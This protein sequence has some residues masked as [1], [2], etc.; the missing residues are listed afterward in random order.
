[1]D[2]FH[3]LL[4]QNFSFP[5]LQLSEFASTW[6]RQLSASSTRQ[7]R[8]PVYWKLASVPRMAQDYLKLVNNSIH[9]EVIEFRV[10]IG[11][12][13]LMS[14]LKIRDLQKKKKKKKTRLIDPISRTRFQTKYFA[15]YYQINHKLDT[16]YTIPIFS[17]K[18]KQSVHKH[19]ATVT[20][21]G[22]PKKSWRFTVKGLVIFRDC[23][24]LQFCTEQCP[25][26]CSV[27]TIT[28]NR[29]RG[30]RRHSFLEV[31]NEQ[32]TIIT[33]LILRCHLGDDSRHSREGQGFLSKLRVFDD[34]SW[35]GDCRCIPAPYHMSHD[36]RY[37]L[38]SLQ[39]IWNKNF[40][41]S[42]KAFSDT[43]RE[44]GQT[45]NK[46]YLYLRSRRRAV[47]K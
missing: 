43:Q 22:T 4:F 7:P 30:R 19:S 13:Y 20:L 42:G 37:S 40:S 8:S 17:S 6:L 33:L 10:F 25:F 1:M 24:S 32:M 44:E 28:Q 16:S 47:S 29:G 46:R 27:Q 39:I 45:E 9:N 2:S 21:S 15:C 34:H 38:K 26:F 11:R 41:N 3:E 36:D 35:Y 14:V 23:Y 18:T 5:Q 12:H 31:R